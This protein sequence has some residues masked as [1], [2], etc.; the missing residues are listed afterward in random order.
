MNTIHYNKEDLM[1]LLSISLYVIYHTLQGFHDTLT[2][3]ILFLALLTS[4]IYIINLKRFKK[5]TLI[6]LVCIGVITIIQ[7]PVSFDI[8]MIVLFIC[9]IVGTYIDIDDLLQWMFIAKLVSFIAGTVIGW[10]K[11]NTC[12]LHGGMLLLLYVCTNRKNIRWRHIA[13]TAGVAV[14]LFLYTNTATLLLGIGIAL[15]LLIYYKIFSGKILFHWKIVKYVFPAVL[16]VNLVCVLTFVEKQVPLIG[17]WLP[18]KV[19]DL[20]YEIVR[21]VDVATTSRVTLA[22]ASW[23][24]FGVSLWGGNADYTSLNLTEGVYYNLDSGMMWLLQGWGIILT[25]VFMLITIQLMNYL[26]KNKEYV[27]IIVGIVIACWAMIEDMLLIVGTNFL[28][29]LFGK[30]L[31]MSRKKRIAL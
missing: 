30:A 21:I 19:N 27:L 31:M 8:R 28:I 9:M 12:A 18:T 2:K 13:I 11:A 6:L 25:I 26:M 22:A 29:V 23:P 1:G 24:V 3:G 5:E 14:L 17:Q 7:F 10:E 16:F 15:I 4:V 20:F